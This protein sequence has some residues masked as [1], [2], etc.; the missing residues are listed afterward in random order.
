MAERF[1]VFLS[2]RRKAQALHSINNT[3]WQQQKKCMKPTCKRGVFP[4]FVS[5]FHS[6][7]V[8]LEIGS[9]L[10]FVFSSKLFDSC[11]WI[12]IFFTSTRCMRAGKHNY[13]VQQVSFVGLVKLV[14]RFYRPGPQRE[15]TQLLH[16][17]FVQTLIATSA[18][19][20]RFWIW[21]R[22]G[23]WQRKL[24]V[25]ELSALRNIL[26][27][28]CSALSASMNKSIEGI[29]CFQSVFQKWFW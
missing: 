29:F 15:N 10:D 4:K 21:P 3:L 23:I 1:N 8:L 14:I 11:H 7:Q 26:Y 27:L 13:S 6:T 17:H 20:I 12:F 22:I 18:R 25:S 16:I 5:M 2:A 28:S 19:W 9:W 24:Q